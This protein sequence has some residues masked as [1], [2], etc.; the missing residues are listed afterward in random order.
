M[1][2]SSGLFSKNTIIPSDSKFFYFF[3]H[4]R[5]LY[6]LFKILFFVYLHHEK[7]EK[8]YVH[9]LKHYSAIFLLKRPVCSNFESF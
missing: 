8:K 7:M 1:F 2:K 6:S 3:P 4:P 9:F 5:W